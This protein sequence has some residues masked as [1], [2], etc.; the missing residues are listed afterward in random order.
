MKKIMK[1][2]ITGIFI[3]V[4]FGFIWHIGYSQNIIQVQEMQSSFMGSILA[5]SDADMLATAYADGILNKVNG[6]EDSLSLVKVL[7]GKPLVVSQKSVSNS[8]I[9]WPSII[10]WN[11]NARLAYIAETR[12][13][14]EKHEQVVDDV[15]K[16]LP[17]GRKVS[18][19]DYNDPEDPKLI[20]SIDVGENI[21]GVSINACSDL[22][23]SGT[24][25]P[26]KEIMIATL[27]QGKITSRFYFSN[28]DIKR[29][30]DNNS[31]IRTIE[32]HPTKNIIAVNLNNTHLVFYRI[33]KKSS[34][35]NVEQ[36]GEPIEVAKRWSVGNWHPSGNFFILTD[37]AW[38]NGTMGAIFNGKGKL[39][40]VNFN[41]NGNHKIVSTTKVG[42]SPEG[43]DI[44]RDGK[45]AVV[46]NMRRTYGPKKMWFVPARKN[47][48]LSL[49]K[50]DGDSG[51]LTTL[52]KEYLFEGALP[53]DAIFDLE[54]NSIA[55]AVYQ[56]QDE[57]FPKQ[58]W[59]DFWEL[60]ND[61]LVKTSC[62]IYVTRGVHNLLLIE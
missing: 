33:N 25:E 16:D 2:T 56:K 31:G 47:A 30:K 43:F 48:S 15:W 22:L 55:V 28:P 21:Q 36:I 3:S 11:S 41:S 20:Q 40:S 44:S 38:G 49:V 29:I 7:N 62:R 60:K 37:V 58:G 53:E 51:V 23:V 32:F 59:I 12:G 19:V 18:V 34:L 50:I 24:T 39:V 5:T 45:Y 17:Q 1:I 9:S 6:I 10:A 57:E 61:Q 46:A 52:G 35:I 14:F 26:G 54:S 8:V 13:V 42:L 27:E 4:A